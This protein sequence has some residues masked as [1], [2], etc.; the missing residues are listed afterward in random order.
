MLALL[1]DA[2]FAGKPISEAQ[3]RLLV[4]QADALVA[5]VDFLA[6]HN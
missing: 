2:E 6:T 1:N 5:Y 4:L 3:E